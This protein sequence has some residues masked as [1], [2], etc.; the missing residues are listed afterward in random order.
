M[1]LIQPVITF[2]HRHFFCVSTLCLLQTFNYSFFPLSCHSPL[3]FFACGGFFS[4]S[5]SYFSS[6]F[7]LHVYFLCFQTICLTQTKTPKTRTC[8]H[9]WRTLAGSGISPLRSNF[10]PTLCPSQFFRTAELLPQTSPVPFLLQN[11][12]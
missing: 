3:F 9:P 1:L 12:K 10:L 7:F 6:V 4:P 11:E 2:S 8:P 5:L